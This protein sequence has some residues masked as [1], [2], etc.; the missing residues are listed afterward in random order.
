MHPLLAEDL[1]KILIDE[2]IASARTYAG[3]PRRRRA[4]LAVGRFLMA[5]GSRLAA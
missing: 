4:R 5:L 1:A 2:R 3:R